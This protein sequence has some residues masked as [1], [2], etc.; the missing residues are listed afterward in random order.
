MNILK[1]V[2]IALIILFIY[3]MKNKENFANIVNLLNSSN[4]KKKNIINKKKYN[5]TNNKDDIDLDDLLS[6]DN[7]SDWANDYLSSDMTS[8]ESS[9]TEKKKNNKMPKI[10]NIHYNQ[11]FID[12]INAIKYLQSN[13]N[14][15]NIESLPVKYSNNLTQSKINEL[16][17]MFVS[18]LN[19][20]I[21]KNI[22]L[23]SNV[24][25]GWDKIQKKLGVPTL[26]NDDIFKSNLNIYKINSASKYST[27]HQNKYVLNI[28]FTKE[29]IKEK[30]VMDI[31]IIEN[32]NNKQLTINNI[33]IQGYTNLDNNNFETHNVINYDISKN[34]G[35]N[36][37]ND[38]TNLNEIQKQLYKRYRKNIC[39]EKR[40]KLRIDPNGSVF[41]SD[42]PYKNNVKC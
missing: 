9:I 38:M 39:H 29:N 25:S 12:V 33:Y 2:L 36:D 15:F 11:N 5:K 19:K 31:N 23:P 27:K 24:K 30:I 32:N 18:K 35:M 8:N 20:Y 34:D 21:R 16:S 26:Y 40:N 1:I 10:Y 37:I 6:N 7:D 41:R 28:S 4:N 14:I 3:K 22:I 17:N 42:L 13:R